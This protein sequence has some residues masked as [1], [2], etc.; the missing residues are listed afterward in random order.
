LSN[1]KPLDYDVLEVMLE[2]NQ[3]LQPKPETIFKLK[4]YT[5]SE[6]IAL[7]QKSIVEGVKDFCK[8]L[9]ACVSANGVH[10][11]HKI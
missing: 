6:W 5:V 4:K 9:E 8:R 2:A 7:L 1:Q 10:F 3:K 11:K